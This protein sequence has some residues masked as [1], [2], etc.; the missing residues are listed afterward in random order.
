MTENPASA[1]SPKGRDA[2]RGSIREADNIACR[3]ADAPDL[4][5]G[6]NSITVE[7][8]AF[9]PERIGRLTLGERLSDEHYCGGSHDI[10]AGQP[11]YWQERCGEHP[12]DIDGF[13]L[14][15]AISQAE[16]DASWCECSVDASLSPQPDTMHDDLAEAAKAINDWLSTPCGENDDPPVDAMWTVSDAILSRL[17]SAPVAAPVAEPRRYLANRFEFAAPGDQQEDAWLVR[18]CDKDVREQIWTG[19]DA[20]AEAWRSWERFAPSYN[21]YVFRLARLTSAP[22]KG[23][24]VAREREACAKV[25]EA[26]DHYGHYGECS[27]LSSLTVKTEIAAAIRARSEPLL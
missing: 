11:I 21:I 3:E 22:V 27:G 16:S 14:A 8:R 15:C 2:V 17:T 10:P 6:I 13:C 25:A 5:C 1:G 12:D 9:L 26:F 4:S 7:Q 18:F 20:E 19:P 23:E 24:A